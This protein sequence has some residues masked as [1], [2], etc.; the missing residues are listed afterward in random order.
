MARIVVALAGSVLTA[1]YWWA[2]FMIV[3]GSA[4]FAGDRGPGYT[5]PSD[6]MMIATN[7][8]TTVGGVVVY[9]ALSLVWRRL[10]RRVVDRADRR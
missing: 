6:S 2:V 9:A 7:L 10:T 1:L 8:A 5:P 3:Y 4:L